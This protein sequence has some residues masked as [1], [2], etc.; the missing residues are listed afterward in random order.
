ATASVRP[1]IREMIHAL[2]E[3]P[4]RSQLLLRS[5]MG[6][7]L[8]HN[9]LSNFL[10]RVLEGGRVHVAAIMKR[11]QELGELRIDLEPLH[12]P[13]VMQNV[14]FCT[15]VILAFSKAKDL[16]KWLKL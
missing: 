5:L 15:Q 13:R 16:D 4:S 10:G 8:T 11:G 2:A 6:V 12:L 7:A 14:F 3:R 9:S 1:V